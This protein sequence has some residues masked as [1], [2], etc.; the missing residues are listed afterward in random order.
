LARRTKIGGG[1]KLA[2]FSIGG[3]GAYSAAQITL[4]TAVV[5]G[6]VRGLARSGQGG[7]VS[8]IEMEGFFVLSK[9]SRIIQSLLEKVRGLEMR[10]GVGR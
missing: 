10:G 1:K 9:G 7:G 3:I 6:E 2:G 4:R 5:T 8:G